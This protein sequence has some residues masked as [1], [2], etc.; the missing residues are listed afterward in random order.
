MSMIRDDK[1][2][3]ASVQGLHDPC[4]TVFQKTFQR[5]SSPSSCCYPRKTKSIP[6]NVCGHGFAE[7]LF[8]L[9]V[10]F[11]LRFLF[12]SFVMVCS[13]YPPQI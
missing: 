7:V 11:C 6:V 4:K 5:Y 9:H 10:Y 13:V 2:Y 8:E 12:V 3:I 1:R